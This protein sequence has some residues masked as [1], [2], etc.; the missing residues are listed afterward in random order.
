MH[1]LSSKAFLRPFIFLNIILDLGCEWA[2]FPILAFYTVNILTV[3]EPF[4]YCVIFIYDVW[5]IAMILESKIAKNHSAIFYTRMQYQLSVISGLHRILDSCLILRITFIWQDIGIPFDPYWGAALIAT[6]R[7]IMCLCSS[8]I[9]FRVRRKPAFALGG[10]IVALSTFTLGLHAYLKDNF[11][12][13]GESTSPIFTWIPMV[14][15][16]YSGVK[17]DSRGNFGLSSKSCHYIFMSQAIF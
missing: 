10:S 7:S 3:S 9:L 15:I 8:A 12:E 1:S 11:M 6:Y 16:P 4:L 5:I 14:A 17:F 2:G 13:D